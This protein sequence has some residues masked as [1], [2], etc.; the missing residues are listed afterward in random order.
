MKNN[1]LR[2]KDN[3]FDIG[4][5][6]WNNISIKISDEKW[7]I[8][9]EA[10]KRSAE[11]LMEYVNQNRIE[12]NFLIYPVL[13]LCR[14][15]IELKLKQIFKEGYQYLHR[16]EKIPTNHKIEDL[17]K[18]VKRIVTEVFS[19]INCTDEYL[20]ELVI[21]EQ[22]IQ[23]LVE[24]DP[25]S[26]SFRYPTQKNGSPTLA[27][28][29]YLNLTKIRKTMKRIINTLESICEEISLLKDQKNEYINL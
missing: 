20:R 14:H 8:Y 11:I 7:L 19:D 16:K 17:F 9:S 2:D 6:W 10:Y 23:K 15:Y 3:P 13:F 27:N 25:N 18:S 1:N 26:I 5:D 28:L 12:E 24:Y 4:N 29:D 22:F 21:M